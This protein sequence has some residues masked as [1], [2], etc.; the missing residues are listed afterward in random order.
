MP[1]RTL[2]WKHTANPSTAGGLQRAGMVNLPISEWTNLLR[3]DFRHGNRLPIEGR[4]LHLVP[5][6]SFIDVHHRADV[7]GRE[8]ISGQVTRQGDA[9]QFLNHVDKGYA[10]MNR[11]ATLPVS[12][13]HTLR[14]LGVRPEGV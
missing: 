9:V 6:P 3:G 14:R 7:T 11:G 10:V 5:T 4:K 13:S 8:P 12:T 1:N 2:G